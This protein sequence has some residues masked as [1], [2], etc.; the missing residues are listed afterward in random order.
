MKYVSR[1]GWRRREPG[2]ERPPEKPD[3]VNQAIG[4]LEENG[5][6][7]D[8]IAAEA[9]L[10]AADALTDRLCLRPKP[11]LRVNP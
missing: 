4:L 8:A 5:V 9:N 6:T 2:P 1:M 10:L 3:L 7:L 11:P